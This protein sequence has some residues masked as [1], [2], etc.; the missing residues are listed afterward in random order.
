[1]TTTDVRNAVARWLVR[2]LLA[3]YDLPADS[4]VVAYPPAPPGPAIVPA[5]DADPDILPFRRPVP[6]RGPAA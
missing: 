2:R 4:T 6:T 3:L 5:P 1:M